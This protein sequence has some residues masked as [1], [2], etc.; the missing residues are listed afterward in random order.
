MIKGQ[1]RIKK[2]DGVLYDEELEKALAKLPDNADYEFL[3][4][5]KKRNRNLPCVSYLFSVVLPQIAEQLPEHPATEALYRYFEDLFAPLHSVT[6]HGEKY[7]YFD[8]KRE[9]TLIID[10]AIENIINF[11]QN[12]WGLKI[13]SKEALQDSENSEYYSQAYKGQ[14]IDWANFFSHK[15]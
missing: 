2:V 15:S 6:I 11:A 8:L 10:N 7:D 14:A 9:K 4:V 3:I 1:G 13:M 12:E 5:D